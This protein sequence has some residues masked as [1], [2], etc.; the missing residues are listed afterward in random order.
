MRH[1]LRRILSALAALSLLLC[2]AVGVMW[3][4]SHWRLDTLEWGGRTA[5]P[6]ATPQWRVWWLQSGRG[7]L[8]VA[9]T[10]TR[11]VPQPVPL[12]Y[13]DGI[14]VS[15]KPF[16]APPPADRAWQASSLPSRYRPPWHDEPASSARLGFAAVSTPLPPR[17]ASGG[18]SYTSKRWVLVFPHWA[19]FAATAVPPAFW[20]LWRRRRLHRLRRR[21][22]CARC[23]YDLRATPERCPECGTAAAAAACGPIPT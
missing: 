8:A 20:L 5:P 9:L 23:G 15:I 12:R 22:L 16:V 19:A 7:S 2:A 17:A 3:A 13:I 10:V 21:G 1:W 6:P 11:R 4:R 14:P 18:G